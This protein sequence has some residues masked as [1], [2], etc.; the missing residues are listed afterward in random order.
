MIFDFDLVKMYNF[1]HIL[2]ASDNIDLTNAVWYNISR[3]VYKMDIMPFIWIAVI[4]VMA[5]IEGVTAQLVSV[6]FVAGALAAAIVSFF[7]PSFPIQLFVFVGVSVVLLAATRPFVRK[8]KAST[9][10]VPTNADRFIGKTA[11]VLEDIEDVKGSGQ[12]KVGGSVWSAKTAAGV[13]IPKGSE[14][15]VKEIVGV[16]LIVEP[17]A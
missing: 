6:W 11:V 15:T 1:L 9:K 4:V 13:K 2:L 8:L 7:T 5:I 10:V 16:K 12:V 14:V 17:K 3:E